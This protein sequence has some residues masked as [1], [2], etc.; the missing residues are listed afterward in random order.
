MSKKRAERIPLI[1]ILGPTAVGKTKLSLQLAEMLNGEIISADSRLF[2]LG[3]DIGTA[4][5]SRED[6]DRVPHHLIDV[7]PPDQT[8]SLAVYLRQV[9]R[10]V[11]NIH[12]RGKLAFLVGGTG[13][14][15][16]AVVEGWRLPEVKPDPALRQAIRDWAEQIGVKGLRERLAELDPEAADRIDGPNLRRMIRAL[17]VIFLSGERFS[18][19]QGKTGSPFDILQIGLIRPREDLYRRIDQRLEEMLDQGLIAEVKSLLEAGYS[20]DLPAMSAIGYKQIIH[21]LQGVITR[22]EAVRQIASKS[23][24][25]VRQQANW[26]QADDPEIHWFHPEQVSAA[27]LADFIRKSLKQADNFTDKENR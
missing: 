24:K 19:Q 20:P 11:R 21:Y 1:I 12:R 26:F 18:E 7:S 13:Q 9:R 4:K 27:E 16:R 23:R 8:W 6:L 3:M 10:T 15:I 25:Y 2:Y 5:P 14:Y 17:E 22:E